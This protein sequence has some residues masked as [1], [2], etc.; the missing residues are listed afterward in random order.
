MDPS[1]REST[2][3]RILRGD[4]TIQVLEENHQ[5]EVR[6]HETMGLANSSVDHLDNL[7]PHRKENESENLGSDGLFRPLEVDLLDDVSTIQKVF[8]G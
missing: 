2:I 4:K 7:M 3:E 5:A 6:I 8:R 1:N